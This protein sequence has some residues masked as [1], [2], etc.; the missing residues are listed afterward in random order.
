[1]FDDCATCDG[2][3]CLECE[4]QISQ[5]HTYELRWKALKREVERLPDSVTRIYFER[6]VRVI[7][8]EVR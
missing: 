8:E 6:M 7:E 2:G 3:N 1:M 5:D 4:L